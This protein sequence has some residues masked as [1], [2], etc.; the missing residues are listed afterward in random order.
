[1][2]VFVEIYFPFFVC[3]LEESMGPSVTSVTLAF[4][5]LTKKSSHVI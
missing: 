5:D 1:M 2:Q 4:E 3:P